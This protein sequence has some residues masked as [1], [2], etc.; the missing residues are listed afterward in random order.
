MKH[1]QCLEIGRRLMLFPHFPAHS[2]FSA[3]STLRAGE[4]TLSGD[5]T[6]C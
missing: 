1:R 4:S 5:L 2:C 6:I 3:V